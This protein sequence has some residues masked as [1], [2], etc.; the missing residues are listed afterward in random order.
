MS[1]P[2]SYISKVQDLTIEEKEQMWNLFSQYYTDIDYE[3]FMEDLGEKQKVLLLKHEEEVRGF[4]TLL[5]YRSQ[6]Q[7]QTVRVL[8]TGDTI[9]DSRYWGDKTMNNA[10]SKF[11]ILEWLS[12]PLTPFYWFLISKGYKTYLFL[13]KNLV[14]YWPRYDQPTPFKTVGLIHHLAEERYA[15]CL[16]PNTGVLTF[17]NKMGRLR[18]EAVPLTSEDLKVPEIAFFAKANPGHAHGDELCCLGV[19]NMNLWIHQGMK[20]MGFK[21]KK[22]TVKKTQSTLMP[23]TSV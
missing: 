6:Y 1:K 16:N 5:V 2:I 23:N 12:A 8:F 13:T 9:K 17:L 4:S 7:G 21:K 15:G 3:R 10:F 18:D 19:F 20:M 14:E 22:R 11:L